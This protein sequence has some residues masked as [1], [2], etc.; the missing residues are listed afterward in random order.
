MKPLIDAM[1]GSSAK[2]SCFRASIGTLCCCASTQL[3]HA[4]TLSVSR[5]LLGVPLH[6]WG[7]K[8]GALQAPLALP[9][10][11]FS[12]D[13]VAWNGLFR[14]GRTAWKQSGL[15]QRQYTRQP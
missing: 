10:Q 11:V 4:V 3:I 7:I 1:Q 2:Q 9:D 15:S 6:L 8:V 5:V 13:S 14:R 12:V